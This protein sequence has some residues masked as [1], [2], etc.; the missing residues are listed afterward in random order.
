MA[1]PRQARPCSANRSGGRGKCKAWAVNGSTVC[2]A[3]GARAPQVLAAAAERRLEVEVRR[4]LARLDT[5]AVSDPLTE[6]SMLAGQVVAWKNA[7]A[8][9]VNELSALRYTATPGAGTEQLRAE[10]ALWERAL[11]RCATV[12]GLMAKLNLDARLAA[13][14]ERQ[15]DMVVAAL[16]ATLASL[17]LSGPA[18]LEARQVMARHLRAVPS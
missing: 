10:V 13:I 4:T 17:G 5:D 8:E 1:I 14:S 2:R 6:L 7:L 16:D 15:A 9:R 18:A 11:D 12:L 3:H